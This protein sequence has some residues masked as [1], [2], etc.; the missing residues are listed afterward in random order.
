[1]GSLFGLAINQSR[2]RFTPAEVAGHGKNGAVLPP[3]V[4]DSPAKALPPDRRR[5]VPLPDPGLVERETSYAPGGRDTGGF[6]RRQRGAGL[7][8]RTPAT[9]R[10]KW[11]LVLRPPRS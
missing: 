3:P 7:P 10:R 2:C 9:L 11:D 4:R 5:D 8:R 6:P 1:M